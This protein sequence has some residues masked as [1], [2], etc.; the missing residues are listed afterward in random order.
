MAKKKK[1]RLP[2]KIAGV[3]VP[4][5]VRKGRFGELLASQTGQK[6]I[7]EALLGGAAILAGKKAAESPRLREATSK[8]KAKVADT[9]EA[10]TPSVT[11]GALAAAIAA[12]ARSF[13]DALQNGA[14]AEPRSF[15]RSWNPLDGAEDAGS[16]NEPETPA[17][18]STPP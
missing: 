14:A 15:E 10:A 12:A 4:K 7:A 11:D 8:A 3:R 9:V 2:K 5:A 17:H 13:A 18:L 1:S 16:S 6:L